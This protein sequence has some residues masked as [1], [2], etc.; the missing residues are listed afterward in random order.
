MRALV[1]QR[2]GLEHLSLGELPTPRA[3]DL[4]PGDVLLEVRAAALNFRDLRVVAGS[5]DP[6]FALPL[7]PC[8]DALGRVLT[9]GAEVTNV[10][11]GDRVLPAFAPHWL[12]GPPERRSLRATFGAPLAGTAAEFLVAPASCLVHAPEHLDDAAASTLCCAGTTAY[13]ALVELPGQ[14]PRDDALS[15]Q[16]VLCLGTGG[17]SVFA[18]QIA[19]AL[20]ARVVVT[21]SSDDKLARMRTLGADVTV[22]YRSIPDWGKHI[23]DATGGVHHVIEVGGPGTLPQ[24]LRAV[25]PGGIVSLIGVLA[26]EQAPVDLTPA[27]MNQVRLQGVIVGPRESLEGVSELFR[28]KKLEP[29]VGGVFPLAQGVEAFRALAAQQHVGKICL[30]VADERE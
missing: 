14:T 11:V 9:V 7:V 10:A 26:G 28:R 29:H 8:S 13:R 18:L 2:F 4:S 25:R 12:T 27:V 15:E 30:R 22:N 20:G 17:V 23:R 5:Y 16:W 6:R 3:M 1:L 19:K 24:S 21:S